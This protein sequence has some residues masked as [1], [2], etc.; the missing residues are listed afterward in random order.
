MQH[1][2]LA[3]VDVPAG[4][5]LGDQALQLIRGA[6]AA[7]GAHV[8]AE[9][10]QDA[11]GDGGQHHDQR[12][13]Q[14]AE[15]LQRTGDPPGHGLGAVDRVEL[16]NHLAGHELRGGDDQ[17]GEHRR[18][19]DRHAVGERAAEGAL[20]DVRE[21]GLGQGADADRGHGDADLDGG[22]VLVDVPQL[23]ERQ[24]RAAHAF[25]AHQLKARPPRAHER[26]LGDDEERIDRDQHGRD[27]ELQA[28]H[29]ELVDL[30]A[31]LKSAPVSPPS[32][33]VESV[34]RTML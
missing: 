5:G 8:H 10:P 32:E 2:R 34:R 15:R 24:R 26:V 12:A 13:E 20:E 14:H 6:A 17:E 11:V 31:S 21:R 28:V 22:D 4:V 27:D 29:A 1:A 16:G 18:D 25:L 33:W 9:Q 7:L 3:R 23:L 30:A 19:G